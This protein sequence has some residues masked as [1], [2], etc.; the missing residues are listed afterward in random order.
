MAPDTVPD[1]ETQDEVTDNQLGMD[2]PDIPA[3]QP[4]PV[5]DQ[6]TK[7]PLPI[8]IPNHILAWS[9]VCLFWGHKG[10]LDGIEA[11]FCYVRAW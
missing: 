8:G 10:Y 11:L 6:S 5:L 3:A 1:A 2:S 9:T 7:P 4:D